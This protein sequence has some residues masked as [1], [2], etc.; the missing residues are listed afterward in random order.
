MKDKTK[1][2]PTTVLDSSLE[3]AIS[4][5]N[6]LNEH[7]LQL[8]ELVQSTVGA[9]VALLRET[10]LKEAENTILASSL[11]CYPTWMGV[12]K[13]PFRQRGAEEDGVTPT[14]SHD[15][16]IT[17]QFGSSSLLPTSKVPAEIINAMLRLASN[18]RSTILAESSNQGVRSSV[19]LE[20]AV[21]I[22][23]PFLTSSFKNS[24]SCSIQSNPK[25]SSR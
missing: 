9:D 8:L 19:W 22:A 10:A 1:D 16:M 23:A 6:D 11:L 7:R 25:L 20:I 3:C 18:I 14:I 12:A 21:E 15:L 17:S 13:V 24:L 2:V 4:G 5:W